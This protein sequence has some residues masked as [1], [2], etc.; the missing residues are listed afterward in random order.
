[1]YAQPGEIGQSLDLQLELRLLA[2]CGLVGFPSVGKSTFLSIVTNA[3]P[4]IAPYQFTTLEPNIGVVDLP[5]GRSF[6]LADMPGLIEGA[7][8]GKGLG[9]EFL[10]HIRRCRV[11]IHLVDMSGQQGDPVECYQ[12]INHELASYGHDLAEKPQIVAAG[13]MD[14]EYAPVYLEEFKKAYPD[15]HVFEMSALQHKG[16]NEVLYA[17]M[18]AID[19]AKK[20]EAENPEPQEETVVYQYQPKRPDFY[21]TKQGPHRYKVESEK[22]DRMAE[23]IDFD[24]ENES[25]QFALKL[26]QMGV[27]KAL[28]QAGAR[29]GD[30]VI[31]GRYIMGYKE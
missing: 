28:Y 24:D 7:A 17:A 25:Y 23:T 27:D 20:A 9:D 26:N 19:Q 12:V 29:D 10:R 4:A 13:K 30:Q 2:D 18:D 22:I 3:K 16:V 1:E 31:V 11:L 15:L 21:I 8:E 6:V 5:D 14:D